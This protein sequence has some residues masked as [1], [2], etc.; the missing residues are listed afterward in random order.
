MKLRLGLPK[1][2][3]EQSTFNLFTKAGF[4]ISNQ[5]RSYYPYCD[6]PEL[7]I[8]L[9]RP[10]EMPRYIQD[11][12]I[13]AGLTGYDWIVENN[14]DVKEVLDLVYAKQTKKKVRWVLCVKEGSKFKTVKD[15]AGK[16][17]ATEL[18]NVTKKYLKKNGVKADVEFSWGA[19]EVKPPDLAD[20][21][22][23]V[24]ET[25]S[26]LRANN[27]KIIDTILE[28]ST[29]LIANKESYKEPWKK[30]K[31]D[32]L[33]MLLNG[34][35]IAEDKVGLKMNVQEK[36]LKKVL[37]LLPA[38]Q[39]PTVAALAEKGWVDVDTVI[40]EALAKVLIPKLKEAGASGIIEYPLNKVIY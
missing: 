12:V 20:A 27:L 8:I 14:A 21:I 29:K 5:S 24:T 28:S 35:I 33:A 3:L 31:I 30:A 2:S 25:G 1:G 18:V 10:Q 13:D 16:K 22:V 4:K 19:T 23:E 39:K 38:L 36:G 17:I 11:G 15:L 6:D 37:A 26:S 9:F 34:A 7:E 40:D 32:N